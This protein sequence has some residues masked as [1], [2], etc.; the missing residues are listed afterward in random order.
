MIKRNLSLL[1]VFCLLLGCAACGTNKPVNNAGEETM[2]V[3]AAID[4]NEIFKKKS[5]ADDAAIDAE[6]KKRIDA[7][8]AAIDADGAIGKIDAD[9][10]AIDAEGKKRIDAD[11][12]AID[13]DGKLPIGS[14]N[15]AIDSDEMMKKRFKYIET[16]KIDDGSIME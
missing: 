2:K 15:A 11:N 7:D 13:S 6:G 16:K 4:S 12:A 14:D 3:D 5:D 1:L 9:D 8:N 10:A